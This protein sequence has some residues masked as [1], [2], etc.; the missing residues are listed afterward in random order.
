MKFKEFLN[1]QT[2]TVSLAAAILVISAF[3]SRFLG[4]ARDWL[5]ASRFGASSDLDV[6]FAA[7]RIPDFVYN[8]LILGGISVAFLPLLS[9][10][11]SK[12]KEEAWKFSSNCLNIFLFLFILLSVVS[13][14]FTPALVRLIA[15]G[16]NREQMDLA[17]GLTRLMFI[18]S[19]L[20]GLSSVFSGILQYFNRFVVYSLCP[21]LYNLGIIFGIL[22][23]TPSFGIMGVVM[24]VVLGAFFHLL[25]QIPAAVNCG[26]KFKPIFDFKNSGIRKLFVL[27]IPRT[28]G[29]AANQI[30]LIV[31]TAIAS[32]LPSGSIA[33]FNFA[34]N[35]QYF[36][37][38]IIGVSFAIAAFPALSKTW[39]EDKKEEFL[40]SFSLIFRQILYLILPLSVLTFILRNQIVAIVLKY[41]A[42]SKSAAE[43]TAVSLGIFAFGIFAQSLIP[44]LLRAF[45]SF[46]DTKTPTLITIFAMFLNIA[47]SFYLVS[48]PATAGFYPDL[49]K[50]LFSLRDTQGIS[51]LGLPL[52]FSLASIFQF[53][54]LML[55]LYKRIGDLRLREISGSFLKIAFS[56]ALMAFAARAVLYL[57]QPVFNTGT[58][59]GVFLEAS[60]VSLAGLAMYLLSSV[61]LGSPEIKFI[62]ERFKK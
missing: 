4:V 59:V 45:F 51:L 62:L 29:I 54:L 7:F 55:F 24:G 5:L 57:V 58:F 42:F 10:Y 47:F 15:P 11:F 30:N 60:A 14:I 27:M 49:M 12:D 2:K 31:I 52:A 56:C 40:K 25:I 35:L 38:G 33:I 17:A 22:F 26:F 39:A 44:L 13:F 48:L 36:P 50:N 9:E 37:I 8:V 32:T 3:L 46:Q 6:Y 19:V 53:V 23:L 1:S 34:N 16:F 28:L 18:P 43:L 20:L 21:I 41:G 61:V